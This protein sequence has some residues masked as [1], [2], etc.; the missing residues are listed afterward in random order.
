MVE[1]D[2]ETRRR[3]ARALSFG[4]VAE[5]YERYRPGYSADLLDTVLGYAARPVLSALEVG[6][7]TGKATRLFAGH[8]VRIT[9]LEPDADMLEVLKQT[10]AGMPVTAVECS[11][12]NYRS[13]DVVDLVF[14]A[15]AWH[16]TDPATRTA[17]A[18]QLLAPG[19]VIALFGSS[20]DAADPDLCASIEAIEHE[21][22]SK[23]D[24]NRPGHSWGLDDLSSAPG[25]NDAVQLQLRGAVSVN[26]EEFVGRLSTVSAYLMLSPARRAVALGRI[27]AVLPATVE[28]DTTL[29]LSMARRT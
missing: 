6:A 14:A 4:S 22:L 1:P 10:T 9:A 3:F 17:R 28:V 24:G 20:V 16:W 25:P 7:G 26:R 29:Q 13:D 12:E 2:G 19:G 8:G 21:V 11:L 27:R 5:Q 23:D 18:V 15:S